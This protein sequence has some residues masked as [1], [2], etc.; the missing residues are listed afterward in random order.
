MYEPRFYRERNANNR[1][2]RFNVTYKETDLLILAPLKLN[3]LC[4]TMVRKLRKKLDI[5]LEENPLF[6][7]AVKPLRPGPKAPREVLEMAHYSALV[8]VGPMAAVAGLFA[9]KTGQKVL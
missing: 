3:E 1:L 8:G 9:E 2:K 5:Y 7:E 6:L 4:F